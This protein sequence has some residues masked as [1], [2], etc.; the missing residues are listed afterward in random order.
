MDSARPR[1]LHHRRSGS[2]ACPETGPEI[3]PEIGPE[4]GPET[5]TATAFGVRNTAAPVALG[6][7]GARKKRRSAARPSAQRKGPRLKIKIM[8]V[9]STSPRCLAIARAK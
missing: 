2:E 7:A 1:P 5:G 4:T 3:S 8:E 6:G 9:E